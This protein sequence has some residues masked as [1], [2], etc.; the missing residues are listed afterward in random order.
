MIPPRVL[1]IAGS[2]SGGGAGIQADLKTMTSLHV[3][4]SSVL[5]SITSQNTLGVDG[6]HTLPTEFVGKQI[7]AVLSDIGTDAVKTGMLATIDIIN[8]VVDTVSRYPDATKH[9]VVD[10]VMISTSGSELLTTSAVDTMKQKLFPITYLLTPNVPEAEFILGLEKGS[11]KTLDDVYKAS[12]E[13]AQMGPSYVLLKGGHL[14]QARDGK[15]MMIDVLYDKSTDTYEEVVNPFIDTKNTHGTG[16]TLSSAIASG[17]AKKMDIREAVK[18]GIS[19]V[20]AALDNSIGTIGSGA[21]PLNH[22]HNVV[23]K[24]YAGNSVVKALIE[25]L[26]ENIWSDFIDHKFVRGIADGTLKRE[27]FEHFIKQDYLYLQNYARA[28]AL[29]AYKTRDIEMTA[30]YAKIILHIHHEMK[31]HVEYCAS[32]GITK[33]DILNTPESVYNVAYT[34]YVLDQGA[35]G[36]AMDLQVA[37]APCSLGY[38]EIGRK[39]YNDPNTKREGNPYWQWIVNYAAEDF[40]ASVDEN[41]ALLEKLALHHIS[42]SATRWSEVCEIFKQA[43]ILE[44]QF[45]EMGWKCA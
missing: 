5:T 31:L 35:T 1:T 37:M 17:L 10:P 22:F 28:A 21:G 6:I 3:Y 29:A 34:R 45:W 38:G 26:P 42:T 44:I 13:L 24:P 43:T 19:Y 15:T 39:L 8:V 32:W 27:S 14:P 9:L 4:G 23:A 12:K 20:A 18:T 40:Q 16:C 30:H 2:D 41:R 25:S 33:E 36:D 7:D 11:I